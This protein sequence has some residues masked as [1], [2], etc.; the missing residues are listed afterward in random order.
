M[1]TNAWVSGGFVPQKRRGAKYTGII[2]VADWYGTLTQL[3]GVDMTDHKSDRPTN[4]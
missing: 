4:S 1:R 2:N 3:A